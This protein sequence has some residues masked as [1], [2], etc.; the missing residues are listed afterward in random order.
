[1]LTGQEQPNFRAR[2]LDGRGFGINF[3]YAIM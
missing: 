3:T 2:A 1:M